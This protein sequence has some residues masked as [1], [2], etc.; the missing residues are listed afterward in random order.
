MFMRRSAC[1]SLPSESVTSNHY[2]PIMLSWS[3][4]T[5]G[6]PI[7]VVNILDKRFGFAKDNPRS[8][9]MNRFL[10]GIWIDGGWFWQV[11]S[12]TIRVNLRYQ[13]LMWIQV[14]YVTTTHITTVVGHPPVSAT[15]LAHGINGARGLALHLRDGLRSVAVHAHGEWWQWMVDDPDLMVDMMPWLLMMAIDGEWWLRLVN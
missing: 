12:I 6:Y 10:P 5:M 8:V 13:R 14:T 4:H 1:F 7:I 3:R 15:G 9:F 2:I 11:P